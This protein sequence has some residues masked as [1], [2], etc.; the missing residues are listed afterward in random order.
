MAVEKTTNG[1]YTLS[2][3][4]DSIII[5]L[6]NAYT[7]VESVTGFSDVT[8]GETTDSDILKEF[9]WGTDGENF[10]EFIT[11]TNLN[12]GALTLDSSNEF[13]IE[14]RYSVEILSTGNIFQFNLLC[15]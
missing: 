10:S 7:N 8:S 12:L 3:I 5:K 2:S 13:W 9:R 11:L 14:Y 4:G 1:Y 6:T 15:K